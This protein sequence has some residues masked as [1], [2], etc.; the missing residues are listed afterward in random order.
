MDRRAV[1]RRQMRSIMR[2]P[3]MRVKTLAVEDSVSRS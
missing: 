1:G 2:N 3:I